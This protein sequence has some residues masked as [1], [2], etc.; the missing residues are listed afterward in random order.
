[1]L[2]RKWLDIK[3]NGRMQNVVIVNFRQAGKIATDRGPNAYLSHARLNASRAA[4]S[5]ANL[6]GQ[7]PIFRSVT[8][9]IFDAS[10]PIQ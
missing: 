3:R 5:R 10:A 4:P 2:R 9:A 7:I 6:D 1:L 8:Q